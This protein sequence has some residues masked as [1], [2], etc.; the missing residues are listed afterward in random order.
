LIDDPIAMYMADVFTIPV[1][2]AGLPGISIN[3]GFSEEGL[4]LG[5]QFI[6][7]R[8]GEKEL[9]STAAVM[10]HRFGGAKIADG[11]DL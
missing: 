1:N 7:P 2:M 10:E 3:V 9:L 11:G 6:A 4:P 8:W 5:V